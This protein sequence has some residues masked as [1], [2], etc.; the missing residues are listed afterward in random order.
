MVEVKRFCRLSCWPLQRI[1]A[2]SIHVNSLGFCPES[3]ITFI[4]HQLLKQL[5]NG[6]SMCTAE[7][8]HSANL[9]KLLPL[10]SLGLFV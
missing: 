7:G 1:C 10:Q 8:G 5:S 9:W 6:Y 2:A 4:S 3:L